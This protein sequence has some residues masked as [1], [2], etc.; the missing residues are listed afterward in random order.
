MKPY[1]NINGNS[2]VIKY[3]VGDDFIRVQFSTGAIYSY[4]YDSA[5]ESN[6]EHM[7]MLAQKGS[8]LNSFINTT[9]RDLYARKER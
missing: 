2:G 1:K 9:V 6:I 5:G 3:E 7:K 8:G 4:T